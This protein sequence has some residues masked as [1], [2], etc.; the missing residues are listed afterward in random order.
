[1]QGRISYKEIPAIVEKGIEKCN[2]ISD[3]S[4][5]DIIGTDMEIKNYIESIIR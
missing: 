5:D 4:L 1:M 2:F 3:P